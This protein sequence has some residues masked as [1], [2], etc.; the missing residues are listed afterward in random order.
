MKK[1]VIVYGIIAG[2]IVAAMMAITMPM[3]EK[4][5]LNHDNG[6]LIGYT[7][8]AVALS[9][10]FFGVKSYRDNYAGGEVSFWKAVKI[11]LLI[12]AIAAFMY[13]T[14][15]EF[16]YPTMS[17]EFMQ[18]MVD[19][20]VEELK[21]DGATPAEIEETRKSWEAFAEYYK[22]PFVRFAVTITEILPVGL[23]LTF[24]SAG[25]LRNKKF[26]PA[27]PNTASSTGRQLA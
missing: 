8:M 17:S 23:I 6:E 25:L 9:M 11:G 4:G 10:I 26:L 22:N 3:Y 1:V 27:Q 14:T 2:T 15:W 13:A 12:T 20:Q 5:T 18:Q 21:A 19:S 7:T 16:V 24:L